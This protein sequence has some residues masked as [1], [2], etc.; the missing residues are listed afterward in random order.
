MAQE[1]L[2]AKDRK[3]KNSVNDAK[4][5]ERFRDAPLAEKYWEKEREKK[6]MYH[7]SMNMTLSNMMSWLNLKQE[8]FRRP[9]MFIRLRKLDKTISKMV[10]EEV[11]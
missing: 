8:K 3:R 2:K 11:L 10:G 9:Q 1:N 7:I 4:A 5:L 6:R